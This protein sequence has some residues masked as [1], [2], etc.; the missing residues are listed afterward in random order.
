MKGHHMKQH[1]A[2]G[3]SILLAILITP[4]TLVHAGSKEATTITT[5]QASSHGTVWAAF[6]ITSDQDTRKFIVGHVD[7][8][9]IDD[10]TRKDGPPQFIKIRQSSTVYSD[11][12]NDYD[13]LRSYISDKQKQLSKDPRSVISV[14][15]LFRVADIISVVELGMRVSTIKF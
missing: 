15:T 6:E 12:A 3:L 2:I 13:Q 5:A 1:I 7:T 10:L 14:T 9:A 11:G 8:E 4:T